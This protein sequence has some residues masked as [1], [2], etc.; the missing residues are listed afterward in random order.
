MVVKTLDFTVK[1]SE[2]GWWIKDVREI[3]LEMGGKSMM[4]GPLKSILVPV[5]SSGKCGELDHVLVYHISLLH[6]QIPEFIFH[7][8]FSIEDSKVL[9]ELL[10]ELLEGEHP[11]QGV[12]RIGHKEIWLEPSLGR[13]AEVG[14]SV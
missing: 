12:I 2:S 4:E 3:N 11:G 1:T 13:T 8:I 9:S 5:G 14:E 7:V 6:P 10:H